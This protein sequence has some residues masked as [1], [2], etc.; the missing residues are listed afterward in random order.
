MRGRNSRDE[1]ALKVD[2]FEQLLSKRV[3]EPDSISVVTVQKWFPTRERDL[4]VH[5]VDD[6]ATDPEAPVEY[7]STAERNVWLVDAAATR[8]FVD[9]LRDDPAWFDA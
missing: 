2:L 6:L 9:D 4:A 1:H 3:C 5:L 7:V 8:A